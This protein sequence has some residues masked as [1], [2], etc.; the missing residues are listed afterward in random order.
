MKGFTVDREDGRLGGFAVGWQGDE[1]AA[2]RL[3]GVLLSAWRGEG[4]GKEEIERT[5]SRGMGHGGC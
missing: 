3:N 2:A 1:G 4:G 5:E